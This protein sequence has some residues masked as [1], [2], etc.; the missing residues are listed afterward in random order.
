MST[1]PRQSSSLIDLFTILV[2]GLHERVCGLANVINST[3]N[4]VQMHL[5]AIKT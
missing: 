2:K 5:T 3:N 4:Q 1:Q